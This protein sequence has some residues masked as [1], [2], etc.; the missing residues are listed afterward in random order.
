MDTGAAAGSRILVAED[1]APFRAALERML[2]SA[3]YEVE[4][5][6]NGDA[7]L[8]RL[9]RDAGPRVDLLLADIN[10]PGRTG[11]DVIAVARREL[12]EPPVCVFMSGSLRD[13][14][15]VEERAEAILVKPFGADEL[16]AQ[17]R[18]ALGG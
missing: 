10:L 1:G 5:E 8:D 3:G 12:D 16:L 4:T 14:S 2:R 7:A 17:V 6:N 11:V 18:K 9:L 13:A 15:A